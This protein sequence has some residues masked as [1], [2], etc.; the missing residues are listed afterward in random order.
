MLSALPLAPFTD[1][2]VIRGGA[3][4]ALA[5]RHEVGVGPQGEPGIR[6]PEEHRERLD[7]GPAFELSGGIGVPQGVRAP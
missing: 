7:V 6:V 4:A 3:A 2:E 5:A 1:E